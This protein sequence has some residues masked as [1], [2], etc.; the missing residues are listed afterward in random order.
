M[1]NNLTEKFT[2]A[3]KDLEANG[4]VEKIVALFADDCEVSN[5]T[6]TDNLK[7]ADGAREFWTDYRKTFKK[8]SS[9]FKNKIAV[10]GT[11]ALE[12]TTT[13]TSEKGHEINYSG[14]SI[15]EMKDG[16]ISRFFAYFNPGKLGHQIID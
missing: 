16:K 7:G 11:A 9:N 1:E 5:V 8:V 4:S 14:V 13:G 3:L 6:L 2:A 10:D 12:W 15:L